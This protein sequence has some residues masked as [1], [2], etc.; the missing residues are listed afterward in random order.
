[1]IRQV[2]EHCKKPGNHNA[3]QAARAFGL[4]RATVKKYVDMPEDTIQALDSAPDGRRRST[5][6]DGYVNI[7]YK[8]QRD[9]YR[10]DAIFHYVMRKGYTG[11]ESTLMGRIYCISRNNFPGRK[12]FSHKRYAQWHYPPGITVIKRG[13]LLRYILT[14]NPRTEKNKTIGAHIDKIKEAYPIVEMVE[15]MFS[16]FHSAIMG[17]DPDAVDEYVEKYGATEISGFCDGIKKDI[18]PVKNA[19]ATG[20]SS[21]FVEGC[22]NKFKLIKRTLYGRAGLSTLAKKCKLAFA[23]NDPEFSLADLI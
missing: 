4:S 19:V 2:Q 16:E 6:A 9:G 18:D 8:M 1:L 11:S 23:A 3:S 10:D 13:D 20:V 21:G 7:I 17:K 14:V 12:V 5:P 15:G 22:N